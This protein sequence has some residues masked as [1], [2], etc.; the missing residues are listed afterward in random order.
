M[1][2]GLSAL[3]EFAQ[4]LALSPATYWASAVAAMSQPMTHI[5]ANSQPNFVS[6]IKSMDIKT[7]ENSYLVYKI[8]IWL[9]NSRQIAFYRVATFL[10]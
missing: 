4:A 9:K 8:T 3:F 10:L 5:L 7:I 6:N 1:W 2:G